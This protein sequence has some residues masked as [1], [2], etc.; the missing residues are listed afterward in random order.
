MA[1]VYCRNCGT[2]AQPTDLV[3]RI[4]GLPI[5]STAAAAESS[6]DGKLEL[7]RQ[8]FAGHRAPGSRYKAG[9]IAAAGILL[10][11]LVLFVGLVIFKAVQ[12]SGRPAAAIE[13][14]DTS[15]PYPTST[16]YDTATPYHQTPTPNPRRDFYPTTGEISTQPPPGVYVARTDPYSVVI[17]GCTLEVDNQYDNLD[18][19]VILT[20]SDVIM[21][22]V[23]IQAGDTYSTMGLEAGYY[24]IFIA[25][26][27]DWDPA[28]GLFTNNASY[29]RSEEPYF[30]DTCDLSSSSGRHQTLTITLKA[31]EGSG[32]DYINLQPDA[33]PRISP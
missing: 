29:F 31:T 28:I 32:S 10:F 18:A 17:M 7:G 5:G 1:D 26:G 19:I 16:P 15:T 2:L 27:Q 20:A 9:L 4:C 25:V 14:G 30:Y 24:N 21:K 33:F 12:S 3:C 13:P 6:G 8:G 22:S 11:A 23:Y